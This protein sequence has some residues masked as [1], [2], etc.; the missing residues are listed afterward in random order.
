MARLEK[1]AGRLVLKRRARKRLPKGRDRL[2]LARKCPESI[3][4]V[5]KD[6]ETWSDLVR[7]LPGDVGIDVYRSGRRVGKLNFHRGEFVG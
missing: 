4:R 2:E 1:A 3:W 7:G 6:G 5:D